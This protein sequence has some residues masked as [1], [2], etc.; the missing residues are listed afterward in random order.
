MD[1]A[2][3]MTTVGGLVPSGSAIAEQVA[4]G[5]ASGVVLAGLKAQ[6]A[7]G[8][9]DPLGLFHNQAPQNNPNAIIGSTASASAFAALP[10]ETQVLM[11][12]SGVHVVPG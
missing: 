7:N 12:A 4:V 2:S 6:V 8:T 11:L 10:K 5:A 1:F 9:L 3:L